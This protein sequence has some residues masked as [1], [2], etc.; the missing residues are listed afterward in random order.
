[1]KKSKIET[2]ETRKRI[3]VSAAREFRE[4]GI[5]ET[6]L[7]ELMAA[8]GLTDGGFYRHFDSKAQLVQ[9]SVELA[10]D[11]VIA[12]FENAAGRSKGRRAVMAV[13]EEYLT[14]EHRDNLATGCILAANGSEVARADAAVRERATAGI[15]RLIDI[16]AERYRQSSDRLARQEAIGALSAMVG[17]LTLARV[18]SDAKLSDEIMQATRRQLGRV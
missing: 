10:V 12:T 8:A 6:S 9:E 17:A 16:L 4:R 7:A 1:M 13:V 2:A 5:E 18:A 15:A 14:P 3:I 11:E